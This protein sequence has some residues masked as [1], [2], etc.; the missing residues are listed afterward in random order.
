MPA[1]YVDDVRCGE[2]H[3]KQAD[4]YASVAMSHAFYRPRADNVIEALDTPFFH[5]KSNQYFAMSR[6]GGKLIFSRWQQTPDGKR[7]NVIEQ[8][9]DWIIGSGNHARTYIYRTPSGELFQLPINWYTQTRKWGMAPGYDRPDHDGLARRVRHECMFCH[10]AYPQTVEDTHGYW[11]AQTYPAELPEGLGCQR[12][13][14]PGAKHAQD[15]K[16]DSILNPGRLDVARRNDVCYECHMQASVALPSIRRFGRD[17]YSYRPGT[18]LLDYMLHLDVTEND[19]P[20]GERFEINHHPYRLEQS[21]CFIES[22]GR[23]SCLTCHDPHVKVAKENRAAHYR[24]VCIGCHSDLVHEPAIAATDDCTT[25]HMPQRRTQDVVQV[26]M[27]DHRITKPTTANL[28]APL[29]ERETNLD[30]L[31]FLDPKQSSELYRTV[32]ILRAGGGT[33]RSAL[34]KLESLKPTEIEPLLDLAMAQLTQKKYADLEKTASTIVARE[35]KNAQALEWLGIARIALG[36]GDEGIALIE[37]ALAIDP[38][39]AQTHYNLALLLAQRKRNDAAI[40]HLKE[41]TRLRPNLAAAWFHLGEL[42][43]GEEALASYRRALAI[44]PRFT[45][46]ADAIAARGH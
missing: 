35:P 20:R 2:C 11:R 10:N 27:T 26:T 42:Q 29:E 5:A 17:I 33:S 6:R 19:R 46:A 7:I 31:D 45:R 12:C 25:C 23:L 32:A 21:R 38:T 22:K 3:R 13:H 1:G 16:R 36:K 40:A 9:V 14:G 4:S 34:A 8:P 15:G 41:A 39:R 37:Q 43:T 24:A 28:T 44:E 30:G 18:P